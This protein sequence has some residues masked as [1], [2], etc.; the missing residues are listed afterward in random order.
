MA[1]LECRLRDI[2]PTGFLPRLLDE[3]VGNRVSRSPADESEERMEC[4]WRVL[5]G[6][7]QVLQPSCD[8]LRVMVGRVLEQDRNFSIRQQT[9]HIDGSQMRANLPNPP[10]RDGRGSSR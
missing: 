3:G 5:I 1:S 8:G 2:V 6:H 9:N 7:K 10:T 4:G